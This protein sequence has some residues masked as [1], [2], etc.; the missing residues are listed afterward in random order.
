[1]IEQYI[2]FILSVLI[3]VAWIWGFEYT[4]KEGEIFGRP[5]QWM[6]ANLPDWFLKPTI[7]C[8]YCMS[9]VHG[10]VFFWILLYGYP[11]PWWIAFCFCVCGTT[12]I[13]D[14]D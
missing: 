10:S 14:N 3:T 5:G 4:F 1:M 9:S 13:F 6:R 8:K 11:W 7:D 2:L 12:A